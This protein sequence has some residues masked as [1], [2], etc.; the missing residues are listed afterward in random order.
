M[1]TT[2]LTGLARITVAAPQRRLDLMVPEHV[3]VAE[4]LPSVTKHL[5]PEALALFHQAGGYELRRLDGT[6]LA[7][8]KPLAAHDI[9][10]G[11]ILRLVP[12]GAKWDEPDYDDI[13]E[14]I[15]DGSRKLNPHWNKI[16]TR[17]T[18]L[19]LTI[20]TAVI[21]MLVLIFGNAE[22]FTIGV[23]SL[24]LAT[25]LLGVGTALSRALGDSV[26]G[27][28]LGILCLPFAAFGGFTLLGGHYP[29]LQQGAP[30]ILLGSACL[31]A[32]A[33]G[34]LIGV[35]D[36]QRYFIGSALAGLVGIASAGL[37]MWGVPTDGVAA[38]SVAIAVGLIPFMPLLSLRIGRMPLPAIPMETDD[39]LEDYPQPKRDTVFTS[40]ERTD[41]LLSGLALGVSIVATVALTA[42]A[43]V[44]NPPAGFLLVIA[45][46]G[47]FLLRSRMLPSLR[48]RMPFLITGYWGLT[49]ITTGVIVDLID[50]QHV[51][52]TLLIPVVLMTLAMGL[53]LLYS[54]KT[55]HPIWG[56]FGDI[57]DIVCIVAVVPLVCW[58]LGLF[59]YFYGMF[60]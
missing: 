41:E 52:V 34:A 6:R 36:L 8:E 5:P 15:A 43:I 49:V 25:L 53:G 1:A 40:V 23:T 13:V 11:T 46:T 27:A 3:T 51:V 30:Q 4:L 57:L 20:T 10:D 35:A 17:L 7:A 38:A 9:K 54:R 28:S 33:I 29:L 60:G 31:F 39:V 50:T 19:V 47:V 58:A 22:W 21:A 16:H 55:P 2:H 42:V 48:Q 32:F 12:M 44:G 59:G 26:A 18:G 24:G 37:A 45:G 56:R 14:T